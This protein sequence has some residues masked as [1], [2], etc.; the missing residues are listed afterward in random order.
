RS[1][2]LLTVTLLPLTAGSCVAVCEIWP[3]PQPLSANATTATDAA[4]LG[5]RILNRFTQTPP[6]KAFSWH[7]CWGS[8]K[9][10]M[11]SSRYPP[12]A[13]AQGTTPACGPARRGVLRGCFRTLIV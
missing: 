9:A 7:E 12:P 6:A 10:T 13:V 5:R 8:T 11:H 3:A 2:T 1:A 4:R